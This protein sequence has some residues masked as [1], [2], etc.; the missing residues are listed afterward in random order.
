MSDK[1]CQQPLG[2]KDAW[3][4]TLTALALRCALTK[5]DGLP[6]LGLG[7]N[8]FFLLGSLAVASTPGRGQSVCFYLPPSCGLIPVHVLLLPPLIG[9]D[10]FYPYALLWEALLTKTSRLRGSAILTSSL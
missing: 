4:L 7:A 10:Y 9:C 5:P 8:P 6:I 3:P 2:P 1:R